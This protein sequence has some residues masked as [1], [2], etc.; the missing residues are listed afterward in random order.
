MRG[1]WAFVLLMGLFAVP[2]ALQ[3]QEK[4]VLQGPAITELQTRLSDILTEEELPGLVVW[5]DAPQGDFAGAVGL[6]NLRDATV[7]RPDTAFRIGNL[8]RLF[9]ATLILQMAEAGQLRLDDSLSLWLPDL[10]AQLPYGDQITLLQLL[11]QTSGIA[12]YV[13]SPWF[14]ST[15]LARKP[16]R[17]TP[18][19]LVSA[20][21]AQ[22]KPLF[23]PGERARG[24]HSNTNYLLL[25][26]VIEKVTGTSYANVLHERL[27]LPLELTSTY[28][29][30]ETPP[31]GVQLAHGYTHLLLGTTLI[32]VTDADLSWA[33]AAAGIVSNAPD[34]VTLTRAVFSGSV[35]ND[36][37]SVEALRGFVQV[38]G[39]LRNTEEGSRN[40]PPPENPLGDALGYLTTLIYAPQS[41]VVLIIWTNSNRQR[42]GQFQPLIQAAFAAL[43]AP[44]P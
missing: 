11:D 31:P 25:G 29:A 2:A 34:L 3:A 17:W 14:Q 16:K 10:A 23:A 40:E 44:E 41:D 8:T 22:E 42:R 7:L 13:Q 20:V 12:D 35:F 19:E 38:D 9:T 28:L 1:W 26:L 39:G 6:A 4:E 27:L 24:A 30:G 5:L 21:I 15:L 18:V 43:G 36:P 32:D 37:A 33:W